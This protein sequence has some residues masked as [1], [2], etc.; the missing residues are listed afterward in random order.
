MFVCVCTKYV[1]SFAVLIVTV[2]ITTAITDTTITTDT[3]T[4]TDNT[5]VIHH[6]WQQ[7]KNEQDNDRPTKYNKQVIVQKQDTFIDVQQGKSCIQ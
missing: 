3:T 1:C 6:L 4:T 5:L 2:N 7:H